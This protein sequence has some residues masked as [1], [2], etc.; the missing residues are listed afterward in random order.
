MRSH[1][2]AS[3]SKTI[4]VGSIVSP[5]PF[6]VPIGPALSENESE[7]NEFELVFQNIRLQAMVRLPSWV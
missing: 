5:I 1:T 7:Q 2:L 4:H 6:Y 3:K